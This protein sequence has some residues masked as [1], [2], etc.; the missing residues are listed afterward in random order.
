LAASLVVIVFV[1]VTLYLK[2]RQLEINDER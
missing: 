1:C 2:I